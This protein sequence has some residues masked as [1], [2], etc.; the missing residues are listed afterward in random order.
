M[1]TRSKI[2]EILQ[3]ELCNFQQNGNLNFYFEK[4]FAF[5]PCLLDIVIILKMHV[6]YDDTNEF[7]VNVE[8]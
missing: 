7:A 4:F 8:L 5:L 6:R 2:P 1:L 3:T